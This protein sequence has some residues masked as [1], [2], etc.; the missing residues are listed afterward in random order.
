[1]EENSIELINIPDPMFF[2]YLVENFD[3]DG[4]GEISVEEAK[5][6]T[7]II[8]PATGIQSL[9]GIEYFENLVRLD[10]PLNRLIRLDISQNTKLEELDCRFNSISELDLSNNPELKIVLTKG[11]RLKTLDLSPIEERMKMVDADKETKVL[12]SLALPLELQR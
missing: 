10:C 5:A 1:M 6:V 8:C 3:W 4:D 12:V 7:E 2:N 9:D 11:N